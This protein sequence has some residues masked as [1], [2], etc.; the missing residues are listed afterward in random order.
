MD[1]ANEKKK[2][3]AP[4]VHA[5]LLA[6]HRGDEGEVRRL[7]SAGVNVNG[8]DG[9]GMSPLMASA[10]NGQVSIANQLLEHGAYADMF[11]KWGMSARDIAVWHGYEALAALLDGAVASSA[12]GR[13]KVVRSHEG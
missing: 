13:R 7:L 11:N 10:M 12:K 2:D 8:V 9:D 4:G 3:L 1:A 5:L 6:V